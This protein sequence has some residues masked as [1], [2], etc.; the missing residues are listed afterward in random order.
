M[1]VCGHKQSFNN[2]PETHNMAAVSNYLHD[3]PHKCQAQYCHLSTL[4]TMSND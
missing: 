3:I 1:C 4:C 2:Q